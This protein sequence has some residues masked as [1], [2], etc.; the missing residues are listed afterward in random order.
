MDSIPSRRAG[1]KPN[2]L[3]FNANGFNGGLNY[4]AKVVIIAGELVN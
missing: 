2:S 3:N 4:P 1:S